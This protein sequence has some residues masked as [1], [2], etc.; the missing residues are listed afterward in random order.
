MRLVSRGA[1]L[2]LSEVSLPQPRGP[3]LLIK[4]QACGV[5][6][7]DL[8]LLDGELP[9]IPFPVTPGHEV[10]G[11]V[12]ALGPEATEFRIGDRVGVPWLAF[13]CGECVYCR[14]GRENL[15][16]RAGFTGYTRHGGYAQQVLADA[17]YCLPLPP[18]GAAA[19]LAPLLCAGLIGYRAY[20]LARLDE[21]VAEPRRLGLYGF[22]GAG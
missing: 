13:T 8:H 3:E 10:V 22:G 17:R 21:M 1:P 14:S 11:T 19:E 9:A 15:C 6:R 18:E 16:E 12:A 5:C 4:V 7:T 2:V 20:R